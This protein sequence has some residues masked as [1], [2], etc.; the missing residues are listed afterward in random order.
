MSWR[1]S[2]EQREAKIT[3]NAIDWGIAD[4]AKSRRF[5]EVLVVGGKGSGKTSVVYQQHCLFVNAGEM[6]FG[7]EG[8]CKRDVLFHVLEHMVSVI[9]LMEEFGV[10]FEDLDR[11][12]DFQL[13]QESICNGLPPT[14]NLSA[15]QGDALKRLWADDGVQEAF[16]LGTDKQRL[17]G[18]A[19]YFLND[20]ERLCCEDYVPINMDIWRCRVGTLTIYGG[21]SGHKDFPLRLTEVAQ[22]T[23]STKWL[24]CFGNATAVLYLVDLSVYDG[25][26][27]ENKDA[28]LHESMVYFETVCNNEWLA[29]KPVI[30]LLNKTDVFRKKLESIPLSKCFPEYT[31]TQ[32][33]EEAISFIQ[34][35]FEKLNRNPNRTIVTRFTCAKNPSSTR[36][37]FDAVEE[38]V[39][40]EI[41]ASSE[42]K[43]DHRATSS[44]AENFRTDDAR[45]FMTGLKI[46]F[47]RIRTFLS[48]TDLNHKH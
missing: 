14:F 2:S 8:A 25:K 38:A 42:T 36:Y 44:E 46:F 16:Q 7:R 6:S 30:L 35:Q 23:K 34:N 48:S 47:Q 18:A 17:H 10:E 1:L 19:G 4:V 9:K 45:N 37:I 33:F 11:T 29:N 27:G 26:T 15:D 43:T 40:K 39:L 31:G 32:T 41:A 3:S 13:I 28:D 20:L 5:M 21:L 22:P 12:K 24:Q